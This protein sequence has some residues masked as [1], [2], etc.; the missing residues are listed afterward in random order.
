MASIRLGY[1]RNAW[2]DAHFHLN[3]TYLFLIYLI[4]SIL[5]SFL[6]HFT[7]RMIKTK[8]IDFFTVNQN[9][10]MC[11]IGG[12][13]FTFLDLIVNHTQLLN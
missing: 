11:Q 13:L 5:T 12:Y 10:I 9:E 2:H 4:I 7:G 6:L 8:Q 3:R 1:F